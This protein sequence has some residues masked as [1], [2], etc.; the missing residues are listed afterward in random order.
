M[1]FVHFIPEEH[2]VHN[3]VPNPGLSKNY[4][5]QWYKDSETRIPEL[6]TPDMEGYGLK[7]CVP[8]LDALLSGY[9][10]TTWTNIHVTKLV[11]GSL[12]IHWDSDTT[13]I[14]FTQRDSSSGKLM[15]R[16]AGHNPAHLAWSPK[17]GIKTPKGFSAL[18]THPLNRFD[19]PFTTTSGIIDSDKYSSSGNIPFFMREGFEG[20]I[21]KGT[22]Y[23]QVIPIKRDSWSA[24]YDPALADLIDEQGRAAR[25]VKRG[26]Y[27]D[28]K[29]VKK[30]YK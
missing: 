25:E 16:P 22:P 29:W 4:V 26:Y 27:R 14:P 1:K 5:P 10:L 2:A 24:V 17:W 18:I 13:S 23:A 8:F 11:D 28:K 19:L 6:D 30:L 7:T 20:V 12:D 3:D 21:P 9:M 15:P